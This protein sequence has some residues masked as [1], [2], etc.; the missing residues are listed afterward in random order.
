MSLSYINLDYSGVT[1]SSVAL[2]TAATD[3]A[4]SGGG[5]LYIRP[6]TIKLS[7]TV[8]IS[9]KIG[10]TIR[11]SGRGATTFLLPATGHGIVFDHTYACGI[12]DVTF[13]STSKRTSGSSIRVVGGHSS[14]P[15]GVGTLANFVAERVD[16]NK[17]FTGLEMFDADGAT[18]GGC[19]NVYLRNSL[20]YDG[21][22]DADAFLIN[23]NL[24]G[25][26]V[27]E[28]IFVHCPTT[29]DATNRPA[30]GLRIRATNDA[31]IN[32]FSQVLCKS[33]LMVDPSGAGQVV[34]AVNLSE[35]YFDSN[36]NYGVRIA[37][38]SGAVA[39][40]MKF[41]DTWSSSNTHNIGISGS[42]ADRITLINGQCYLAG[43]W[44]AIIDGCPNTR[45]SGMDFGGATSGGILATASASGFL[46]QGNNVGPAYGSGN[47]AVGIQ[48]DAGCDHYSITGNNVWQTTTP[49]TNTPGTS[50][51]RRIVQDNVIA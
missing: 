45:I 30:N 24:G 38:T 42:G 8:T 13:T 1:D 16:F 51:G 9:N 31:T 46:V 43:G 32:R 4:N 35:C 25:V 26:H 20:Y 49:I 39:E 37:P 33:G 48:V 3:I 41:N 47:P 27:L 40:Q 50:A 17:Q 6:G 44:G 36:V 34:R 18:P 22:T 19:W 28:H 2:S 14:Y 10:V 29:P 12:S 11:G 7:N 21:A 15:I 5:I 23:S